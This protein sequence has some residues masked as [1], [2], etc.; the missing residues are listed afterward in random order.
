MTAINM[1]THIRLL[2][3]SIYGKAPK[4]RPS[5]S[6]C[7]CMAGSQHAAHAARGARCS[8]PR[9]PGHGLPNTRVCDALPTTQ[10]HA[11]G[12][13]T[14]PASP[15]VTSVLNL[16]AVVST[17]TST[18]SNTSRLLHSPDDDGITNNKQPSSSIKGPAAA[19]AGKLASSYSCLWLP[20][21]TRL[22]QTAGSSAGGQSILADHTAMTEIDI[23]QHHVP[24][25]TMASSAVS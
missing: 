17:T 2:Q 10:L 12:S 6:D 18:S 1:Q 3:S 21:R 14:A 4:T 5:V 9:P 25:V 19:G 13:V 23:P 16:A 11:T 8:L 15:V 7:R 22:L 24:L 20:Q